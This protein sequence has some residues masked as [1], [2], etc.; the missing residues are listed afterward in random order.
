MPK[1]EIVVNCSQLRNAFKAH[2]KIYRNQQDNPSCQLLL[3]YAVE[4]GLKSKFLQERG[5]KSTQDFKKTFGENKKHGHGHKI[6]EW[7]AEL[8]IAAHVAA[9]SD[10]QNDPI[11]NAHEKLRYGSILSGNNGKAQISYLRSIETYLSK[12]I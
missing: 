10:D 11:E 7:V 12:N 8:K 3:F 2:R 9:Y 1:P 5:Y 6:S 4:A